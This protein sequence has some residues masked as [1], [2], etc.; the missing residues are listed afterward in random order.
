MKKIKIIDKGLSL[1]YSPTKT[2]TTPCILLV[3]N[4]DLEGVLLKMKSQG[5]CNY[6]ISKDETKDKS[7]KLKT[8]K[9]IK[10]N[11]DKKMFDKLSKM[12][13]MIYSLTKMVKQNVQVETIRYIKDEMEIKDEIELEFKKPDFVPSIDT[14]NLKIHNTKEFERE[15]KKVED[16]D[17]I[18][19]RLKKLREI[20]KK[21]Y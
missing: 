16:T 8:I 17:D 6:K 20:S 7:I 10:D 18:S 11:S 1:K 15:K 4:N 3:G 14:S 12:E 5:I 21:S 13:D 2:L 9:K 19:N